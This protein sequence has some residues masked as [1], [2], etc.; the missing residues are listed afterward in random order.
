MINLM[1]LAIAAAVA[2]Y[3]LT[4]AYHVWRKERNPAGAVA[5]VLLALAVLA[6]PIYILYVMR[7]SS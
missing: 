7:T 1:G 3:T 4:Y 5:V 2:F 6:L